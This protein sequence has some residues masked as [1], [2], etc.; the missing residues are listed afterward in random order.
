VLE[1]EQLLKVFFSDNGTTEDLRRTLRDTRDWVQERTLVNI[2]VGQ[3]Y[4]EGHGPYPQRAAVN[5]LVGRFLDDFLE[6]LDRW[7]GWAEEETAGWPDSP[8]E[9]RV[10]RDALAA[11]VQQGRDRSVRWAR[12]HPDRESPRSVD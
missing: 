9:A 1:F 7:A 6:T 5:T 2:E 3:S 4:L 10:N 8:A 12:D 11:T